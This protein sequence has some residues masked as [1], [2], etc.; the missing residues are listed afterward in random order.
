MQTSIALRMRTH[1]PALLQTTICNCRS[2]D[3]TPASRASS[4]MRPNRPY[5]LDL[6]R[7]LR[8][9]IAMAAAPKGTPA[10]S[11]ACTMRPSASCRPASAAVATSFAA[12]SAS[13]HHVSGRAE[14]GTRTAGSVPMLGAPHLD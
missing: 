1:P 6:G 13:V 11:A 4:T 9:T 3:A 2:P 8:T 7:H 10:S 12:T 14:S 5:A